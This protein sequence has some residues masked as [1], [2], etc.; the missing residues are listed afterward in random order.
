MVKKLVAQKKVERINHL[1][2]MQWK[3]AEYASFKDRGLES[4]D[5]AKHECC[6]AIVQLYSSSAHIG[7]PFYLRELGFCMQHNAFLLY[8]HKTTCRYHPRKA[9]SRF[10]K[11]SDDVRKMRHEFAE[12]PSKTKDLAEAFISDLKDGIMYFMEIDPLDEL[13]A[14]YKKQALQDCLTFYAELQ[15][16]CK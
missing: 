3:T 9:Q 4:A 15:M 14:D 16:Y 8:P 1:L 13:H 6:S 2:D 7:C 5:P 10:S 12:E 11:M